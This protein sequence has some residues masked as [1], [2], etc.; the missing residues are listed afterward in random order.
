M[1]QRPMAAAAVNPAVPEQEGEKL[2]AF[3]PKI[4]RRR[5]A[6]AHK[7]AHRLMSRIG[8]PHAC[9]SPARCR[10][11]SVTASRRFVLMRS[12]DR[13][14]I[15][16]GATTMQSWPRALIGDKARI[17][18]A[19]LQNRHAAGRIGSASSL[20]RLLDRQRA[21][22]DVAEKPDLSGP[23]R[24]PRSQRRASSWRRQKPT[25]TSLYFPMVRPPCMRLGSACPS[26]P[27]S[28]LHE[29]AGHRLSPRT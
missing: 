19:R 10:R 21:V 1:R 26:T 16:A 2:L 18:S 4:V 28:Y 17:P 25:K 5:L 11:A 27:L 14:G 7:I 8:R 13:F 20:D 15:R 12:P 22:L 9:Q 6:G 23:A 3:S 24:L 29:R